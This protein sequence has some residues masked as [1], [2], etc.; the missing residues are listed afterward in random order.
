MTLTRPPSMVS[1][2]A[3]E[4]R[5]A[6]KVRER[7]A[8][9]IKKK[10]YKFQVDL[11][12]NELTEVSFGKAI[13]FAKVR[14][15]D[16]GNF[17]QASNR[18]EVVN[19]A[20]KYDF[21]CSFPS[22][23]AANSS[24]GVLDSCKCRVSI[25]KEEKGGKNFRKI[26]FVDLDLA[27]Y[28]GAGPSTQRYILQAY[29]TSHRLDNSL[30]QITLNI[31]LREGDIVFSRPLTRTQPI[32]LPGEE[33]RGALR[34][35][36]LRESPL[37]LD[38]TSPPR[39]GPLPLA[40]RS[41]NS[42]TG[43]SLTMADVTGEDGHTRNSSTT[44][45][46]GS[47]GYSSSQSSHGTTQV[48][49]PP[50]RHSSGDSSTQPSRVS[51]GSTEPGGMLGSSVEKDARRRKLDSGRADAEAVID[52]LMEGMELEPGGEEEGSG[53]LQL[54]LAKDGSV[55]FDSS[56][57]GQLSSDFREVIMEKR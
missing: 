1:V 51:G 39:L 29:D 8:F 6:R 36:N 25:R 32:L 22:K 30:L 3:S 23:M 37:S 24:T 44:S 15:L 38:P 33:D 20:V 50:S 14:Q 28:A 35:G 46:T 18:E 43:N 12:L 7:M 19:H 57:P 5:L 42:L 11:T 27:E 48:A 55:R 17:Q 56:Q 49:G 9:I 21:R 26:G 45:Q 40:S 4:T 31:T 41:G 2:V 16:G 34:E 53:G 10:R 47:A 54:Y 13:L 52:E